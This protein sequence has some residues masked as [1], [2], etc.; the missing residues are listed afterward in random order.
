MI[1]GRY[2]FLG[3]QIIAGMLLFL[4]LVDSA[5]S[6]TA[7]TRK[8]LLEDAKTTEDLLKKYHPNL[9]AHRTSKQ[10]KSIWNAARS[11]VP[12]NPNF[13]DAATLAQK[14][15]AAVCDEHTFV[16]LDEKWIYR[17]DR[18]TRF[19]PTGLV[20]LKDK[21]YL[22]DKFLK[23][24]LREIIHINKRS[25]SEIISFLRSIISADGC[26]NSDVLFSHHVDTSL[27]LPIFL[28]NYFGEISHF[29]LK[30]KETTTGLVKFSS[31]PSVN[32]H[33]LWNGYRYKSILGRSSPLK[34]LNLD[35]GEREWKFAANRDKKLLVRSNAKK[36]IFYV[37]VPS[38]FGGKAQADAIDE[39]MRALVKA[40]PDYV[41]IDLMDNPGGTNTNAQRFLSYFLKT[42]SRL[43]TTVRSRVRNDI[44]SPNFTWKDKEKHED[45]F[46]S[47]KQFKKTKRRRGQYRLS[48]VRKSFGNKSYR[49][50][51]I[52]LVS[53]KSASAATFVATTLKRK[54]GAIIVG[55]IGDA[56]MTTNCAGAP[57]THT[58]PNSKAA[59]LIPLICGEQPRRSETKRKFAPTR[60][61]V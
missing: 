55:S 52:V 53:P 2:K 51:V 14:M 11:Q 50:K 12:D 1:K 48:M 60:C 21:L 8:Q 31:I 58:L 15:L 13:L 4:T 39:E 3:V 41:I 20:V 45:Y 27:I 28:S 32:L 57:G 17:K 42:A 38:L 25:S 6:Q 29:K 37:Y 16:H 49:G 18:A 10:I 47:F 5:V 43:W 23:Y 34:S 56:S 26:Q 36:S 40:N 35:I 9:Y 19:F 33:E 24:K 22:D 46:K 44:S 54:A 7:L 59:L 30:Y 61:P